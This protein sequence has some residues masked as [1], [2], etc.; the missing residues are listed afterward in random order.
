MIRKAQLLV[1]QKATAT[2]AEVSIEIDGPLRNE[3][4]I[5]AVSSMF[6]PCHAHIPD[7]LAL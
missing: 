7:G 5:L 6:H 2:E 4:A 1:I 3:I